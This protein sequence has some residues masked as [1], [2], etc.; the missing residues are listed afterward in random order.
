M[1]SEMIGKI[2]FNDELLQNDLKIIAQFPTLEEEYAEF[3]IGSWKNHSLW[4]SDGDFKNTQYSD[5]SSLA[6]ITQL[7]EMLPYITHMIKENFD[8]TDIKMV[9]VRNLVNGFV[10]PHK[11]FVELNQNK[12]KYLRVFIPLENNKN[13]YHSD[14]ES[15]FQ[16]Q[17]GEVWKLD[18]SIVHAA[19]NFSVDSRVNLCLDFQFTKN[20]A[21]E[22][23]FLD[24]SIATGVVAPTLPARKNFSNFDLNLK[25]NNLAANLNKNNLLNTLVDLS[26]IHFEYDVSIVDCYDWLL[27]VA[28][29]L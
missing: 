23:I 25:L 8:V 20:T 17:K 15:V 24:K 27:F 21:P 12:K 4:N 3:G 28:E 13:A 22:A 9:R 5:Y 2:T 19:A 18:A 26:K 1:S 14:E 16:M 10:I 11:D 7:G 6:K 29:K